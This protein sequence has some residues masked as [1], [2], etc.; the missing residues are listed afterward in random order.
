MPNLPTCKTCTIAKCKKKNE[1]I[2]KTY[3]LYFF[4]GVNI[5][6]C[7]NTMEVSFNF[8]QFFFFLNFKFIYYTSRIY[9]NIYCTF[10]L[11]L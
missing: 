2:D 6:Q 9:G 3:Y 1:N 10:I 7:W 11:L 4:Y 5:V 8:L